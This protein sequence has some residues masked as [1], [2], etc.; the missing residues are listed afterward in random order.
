MDTE[1][2][3]WNARWDG[4]AVLRI[5]PDGH[6]DRVIELPVSK[7]TDCAFGGT[8]MRTLY[9]TTAAFGMSD[10]ETEAEPMAGDV[11][12]ILTDV[13]GVEKGLFAG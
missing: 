8:D 2:C 5:A 1:G 12:T 13:R 3:L 6:I 7:V 11:F 10:S 9:V 4:G